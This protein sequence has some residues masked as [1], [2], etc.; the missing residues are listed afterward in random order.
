MARSNATLLTVLQ[1]PGRLH[2]VRTTPPLLATTACLL[3]LT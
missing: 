2:S 1:L 3:I